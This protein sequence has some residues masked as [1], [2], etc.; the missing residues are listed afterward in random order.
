MNIP[1]QSQPVMRN[2][3]TAA[4]ISGMEAS[5]VG[6]DVAC[7]ACSVLPFPASIACKLAAR[8]AGCS[9]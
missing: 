5:S 8:A 4:F 9:C 2:V 6:C 3:S 7:T 1:I